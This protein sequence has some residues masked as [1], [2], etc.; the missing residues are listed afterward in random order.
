[1]ATQPMKLCLRAR[2]RSWV[3]GPL[4]LLLGCEGEEEATAPRAAPPPTTT[5]RA[6]LARGDLAAPVIPGGPGVGEIDAASLPRQTPR[7]PIPL[8]R[9]PEAATPPQ[10]PER[11]YLDAL[12][13]HER[14]WRELSEDAREARRVALKRQ[15][16]GPPVGSQL[17]E[18][19][20]VPAVGP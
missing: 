14:E 13:S 12:R 19:S 5:L 6:S 4:L 7:R 16:L 1:M 8:V 17:G 10:G 18:R 20:R 2:V 3:F 9:G 15:M 11:R